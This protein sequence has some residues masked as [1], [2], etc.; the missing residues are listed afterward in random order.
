[1][2][3]TL[4][5]GSEG[6]QGFVDMGI[7]VPVWIVPGMG[8]QRALRILAQ[9]DTG[10]TESSID[11]GVA[12]LLRMHPTGSTPVAGF[13]GTTSAPMYAADLQTD[14]GV[15]V[16]KGELLG[17]VLAAAPLRTMADLLKAQQSGAILALLGREAMVGM[18][19][20][21]TGPAGSWTAVTA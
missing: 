1:M 10:S 20:T 7:V 8:R 17:A 21:L 19:F 13:G 6:A 14:S 9:L 5:S 15:T 16:T 3:G 2:G 4:F 12:N 18:D 11:V